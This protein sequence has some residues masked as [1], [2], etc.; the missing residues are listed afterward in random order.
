MSLLEIA[1]DL[2]PRVVASDAATLSA[3]ACVSTSLRDRVYEEW[4]V[5]FRDL[6]A[7]R[8]RVYC[9]APPDQDDAAASQFVSRTVARSY[10]L[11]A[12]DFDLLVPS[13]HNAFRRRPVFDK[14]SVIFV[15]A[16]RM[17]GLHK[18]Y[19]WQ[20]RLQSD[21]R[22]RSERRLA[23]HKQRLV[24]GLAHV[25]CLLSDDVYQMF[26][27]YL[28]RDYVCNGKGGMRR[29]TIRASKLRELL[30]TLK[31]FVP[32]QVP[33]ADYHRELMFMWN[34]VEPYLNDFVPMFVELQIV[35][36]CVDRIMNKYNLWSPSGALL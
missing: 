17:G 25:K 13:A 35:Q 28:V 30:E 4:D 18:L 1:L 3:L 31:P 24:R 11:S 15:A 2:A 10:G 5:L 29:I 14:R 22:S 16:A 23:L 9:G 34:S 33:S 36:K 27:R 12:S 6:C 19:R 20:L 21:R 26:G 32:P 8:V 7:E